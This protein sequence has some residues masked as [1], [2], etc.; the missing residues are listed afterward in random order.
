MPDQSEQRS[1][2]G[3]VRT[4]SHV[5]SPYVTEHYGF[6]TPNHSAPPAAV[7]PPR[8]ADRENP[9]V[10]ARRRRLLAAGALGLVLMSGVGGFAAATADPG[11]DGGGGAGRDGASLV[12]PRD[13][14]RQAS[15]FDAPG[16][17]R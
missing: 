2:S 8:R 14:A 15:G 17:R 13:G 7:A 11:P 16:D 5:E 10:R 9:P 12:G 1:P 6:A 3:T 4:V